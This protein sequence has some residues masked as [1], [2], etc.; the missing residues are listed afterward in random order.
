MPH[1]YALAMTENLG[2]LNKFFLAFGAGDGDFSLSPGDTHRLAAAGTVEILMFP[3]FQPVQ[4]SQ[5]PLIFLIP[6]I[7]VPG[8]HSK[9]GKDHQTVRYQRQDQTSQRPPQ[10]KR[11]GGTD[12]AGA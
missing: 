2:F 5:I 6:L 7:G 10:K 8:E 1:R 9:N 4:P 3:V 11:Q 12:Y